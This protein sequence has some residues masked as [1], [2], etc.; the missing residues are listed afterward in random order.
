M[1]LDAGAVMSRSGKTRL[2]FGDDDYDFR[3]PIGQAIELQ[4]L[5]GV[6]IMVTLERVSQFAVKDIKHVLRLGLIGGGMD[7]EAALRLVERHLV[8]GEYGRCAGV[9]VDVIQAAV[10]GVDEEPGPPRKGETP[11]ADSPTGAS[12]TAASTKPARARGSARGKSTTSR[13]G[14]SRSSAKAGASRKAAPSD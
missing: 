14:S 10:M 11:P 13:S 7:K 4:E 1:G 3:L 12:D 5:T 8:D 9:A 2:F 6:G